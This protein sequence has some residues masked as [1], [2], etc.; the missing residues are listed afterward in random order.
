MVLGISYI[1]SE[2][3]HLK[4]IGILCQMGFRCAQSLKMIKR[5]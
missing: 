1:K 3:F 4:R 5:L 2:K